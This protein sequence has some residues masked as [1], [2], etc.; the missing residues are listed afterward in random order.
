QRRFAERRDRPDKRWKFN[1]ADESE[2]A[3]WDDY[4]V[5]YE[6]VLHLT[7]TERAPW[8]VVPADHK[9]Y[10][11]WVVSRILIDTLKE[12]DPRYPEVP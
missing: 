4:R 7:S 3:R 1:A 11:N 12:I 2:S 5:A 9:W 6:D 8:F 10:R